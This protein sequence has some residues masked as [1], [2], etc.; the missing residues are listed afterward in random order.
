MA[1]APQPCTP[2]TPGP[3]ESR[4]AQRT[5]APAPLWREAKAQIQ[6][7]IQGLDPGQALPT[8]TELAVQFGCSLAP[9]KQAVRELALEGW[10]SVQ[11][12]RPARV[13]W[14]GSFSASARHRGRHLRTRAYHT[15]YRPLDPAEEAIGEELG[16]AP[17]HPCIV[18][19]R[20]RLL[21]DRAAALSMTYVNPLVFADPARFFLDH[22]IVSGS[23]RAVYGTLGVRPIRVPATLTPGLAD[24]EERQL[25]GVPEVT[26]VLRAHQ[27]TLVEWRGTS[28]VLEVMNAT[29][30]AEVEYRVNRLA[31]WSAPEQRL[32]AV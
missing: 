24:P 26:P 5:T 23:L 6:H 29:Y 27:A 1:T 20:V 22:D 18:C 4:S 25:L 28:L 19:G 14:T 9:I 7:I 11:R 2:G 15:A 12:G 13:Q 16:L 21:D 8:Y 30:T 31:D 10:I 17:G 3:G 32:D